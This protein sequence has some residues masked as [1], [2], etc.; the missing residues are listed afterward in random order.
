MNGSQRS[1]RD[2]LDDS[3]LPK[4]LRTDT[5][6]PGGTGVRL[7]RRAT[8]RRLR[9]TLRGGHQFLTPAV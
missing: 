7:D 6:L 3:R 4:G 2:G 9:T 1:R 8:Q 5:T